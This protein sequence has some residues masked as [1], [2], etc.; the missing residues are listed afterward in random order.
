MAVTGHI[1]SQAMQAISHGV[2]TAIVSKGVVK[3]AGCGQ[4]PTQAPHL[5]Q[6]FQLMLNTTGGRLAILVFLSDGRLKSLLRVL[7][8]AEF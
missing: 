3:P 5:M 7:D 4:T 6:A 2:L 1:L 8:F